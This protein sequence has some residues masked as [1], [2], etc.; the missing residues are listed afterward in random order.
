MCIKKTEPWPV[1]G[2]PQLREGGGLTVE[3]KEEKDQQEDEQQPVVQHVCRLLRVKVYI[4]YVNSRQR[5]MKNEYKLHGIDGL[6]N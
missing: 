5:F 4:K 2:V 3:V 1:A 6:V